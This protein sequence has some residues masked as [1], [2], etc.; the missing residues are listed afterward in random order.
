MT[1]IETRILEAA[2]RLFARYGVRRVSMADIAAEAD[3]SRQ[4]VYAH[5]EGR[6]GIVAA[7]VAYLTDRVFAQLAE[8][9]E[10]AETL[11][12][13]LDTFFEVAILGVYDLMQ[14][15]P[16][17]EDILS[18]TT[19][20]PVARQA[21]AEVD[22]RK[23]TA[24]AAELAKHRARI[25]GSG[26][27]VEDIARFLTV[28]AVAYKTTAPGRDELVALLATLKAAVLALCPPRAA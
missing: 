1:E 14:A 20:H 16:D 17:V 3:L 5:F 21:V 4:T 7:T 27:R 13:S 11:D 19:R 24:L 10:R 26:Q 2:S 22:A 9:W 8:D 6:D 18:I 23:E 12:Q 15:T 25:E 28:T